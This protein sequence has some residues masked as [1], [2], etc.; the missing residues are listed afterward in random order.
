MPNP[1]QSAYQLT[2]AFSALVLTVVFFWG[3]GQ[4]SESL[5]PSRTAPVVH[6]A[7]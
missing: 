6:E 5:Q 1:S 3:L 7:T 2:A 4:S